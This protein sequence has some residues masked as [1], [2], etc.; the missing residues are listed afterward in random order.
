FAQCAGRGASRRPVQGSASD[1]MTAFDT[2]RGVRDAVQ[3]GERSAVS[4]C[5]AA[6]ARIDAANPDLRAFNTVMHERAL[7]KAA[8]VD[9]NPRRRD[10]PLAGV[11]IA[12]KDNLC[13][14]GTRTT[15]SSRIL[16][17]FVPPYD[18]TVVVRLE[19]AGA[20]VV[21]KTNCDEFAMGS[22]TEN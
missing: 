5:E 4:V 6:L 15:A 16:D 9:G 3:R 21:G 14:S 2:V 20:V 18:A 7:Q 10:L 22:S 19:Q 13:T 12:L 17:T 1:R 8:A 11:P